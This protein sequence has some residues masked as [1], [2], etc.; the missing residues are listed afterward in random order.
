MAQRIL[1]CNL[2]PGLILSAI[3][4]VG[5]AAF[6]GSSAL[7]RSPSFCKSC[8]EM[9]PSYQNWMASGA[10]RNHPHCL[11]CHKDPGLRGE[12]TVKLRSL[13]DVVAHFTNSY[14]LP[15]RSNVA[16]PVCLSCHPAPKMRR[17]HRE[18]A[19]FAARRCAQCHAHGPG[20]GFGAEEE[21]EEGK[22]EEAEEG[23]EAD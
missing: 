18:V 11:Y 3:L 9:L 4:V 16:D 23:H 17:E 10:A 1:G 19:Q 22:P 12:F 6:V 15:I 21:S 20:A 5:I 7:E 13:R 2:G 8:H 14:E